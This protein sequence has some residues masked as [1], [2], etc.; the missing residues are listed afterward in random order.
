MIVGIMEAVTI[1]V[2]AKCRIGHFVEAQ[3]L[4]ALGID[5]IDESEVLTPA[6]EAHHIDKHG[7][8]VP[9][10]C[11][12][13]NLGE[14]LRRI[15][16]GA[17]MIRTKGEAGT[18]DVVEAVRHQRQV[19]AD[20]RRLHRMRPDELFAAAKEL[21]A[22]YEVVQW[23]AANGQLPVVNFAAGGGGTPW[24][25]TACLWAAASSSRAT[26]PAA[27]TPSCR[28]SRT[29][30]TRASWLRSARAWARRW[31]ASTSAPC[32]SASYSPPAAGDEEMRKA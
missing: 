20:I 16:E 19:Q 15:N 22:P 18:G 13:R 24:A 11:G 28:P 4:E 21:D 1:P 31:S 29:T 9:F 6:D 26:R 30:R 10:V 5:Y 27:P 3:I 32:P 2:M 7:F 25:A 17:A 12:C 8:K 23:V 14:A